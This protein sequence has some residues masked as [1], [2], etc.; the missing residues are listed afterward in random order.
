MLWSYS[1]SVSSLNLRVGETSR[2]GGKYKNPLTVYLLS[3]VLLLDIT[4]AYR[5]LCL[6]LFIICVKL[7]CIFNF[8]NQIK[9]CFFI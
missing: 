3:L 6:C 1:P 9:P 4:L 5:F 7:F 2:F 8:V